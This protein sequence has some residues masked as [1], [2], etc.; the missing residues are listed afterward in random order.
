MQNRYVFTN[1]CN[2]SIHK[3][4]AELATCLLTGEQLE[5]GAKESQSL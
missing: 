1:L 4:S 3:A 5:P 2:W